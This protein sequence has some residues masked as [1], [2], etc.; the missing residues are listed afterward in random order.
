MPDE[1]QRPRRVIVE[2]PYAAKTPDELARNVDYA[3]LAML[4]CLQRGEAPMLSHLLYTQVLDDTDRAQ[5]KRGIAAGLA[6]LPVAEAHV[7]YIDLDVSRSQGVKAAQA[8]DVAVPREERRLPSDLW[9]QFQAREEHRWQL[10]TSIRPGTLATAVYLS[11]LMTT[12]A[13]I[14]WLVWR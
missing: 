1:E 11:L 5:R 9:L 6:W 8:L 4:D 13:V 12:L 14:A 10:A 2:S 3:R 7:F